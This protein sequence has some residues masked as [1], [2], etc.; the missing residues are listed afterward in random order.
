MLLG[1][2]GL[3]LSVDLPLLVCG[4]EVLCRGATLLT[5]GLV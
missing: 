2:G 4:G 1:L 3:E 5:F